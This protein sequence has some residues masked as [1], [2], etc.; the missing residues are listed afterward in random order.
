MKIALVQFKCKSGDVEE[1]V[2]RLESFS[3]K[4]KELGADAV[5]FPEMS[6]TGYHIP[7][8][9]KCASPADGLPR[10][11]LAETAAR[12]RMWIISGLSLRE[13]GGVFNTAVAMDPNGETV[14]EYRKV[15]LFTGEPVREHES[16]RP[17]HKL[18]TFDMAGIKTGLMVCYDLRFPE[19]ARS[20]M[21]AGAELMLLPAAWPTPRIAHWTTLSTARAIENQCYFLA[22][23]RCGTDEN[24]TLGG[25]SIAVDPAGQVLCEAGPTDEQV[26]V[27][28]ISN[29]RTM[30][31]RKSMSVLSD[32]RPAV[33]R[34]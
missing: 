15:H 3:V 33:Y 21:C 19:M 29:E 16:L 26:L 11:R 4:A 30:S 2:S 7:T 25:R 18:V 31:V 22:V 23:N 8:I 20:L 12:L 14:A 27:T 17:G 1:N 24:L 9:L 10:T 5:V 28:E 34:I 13:D 32:R 6:D